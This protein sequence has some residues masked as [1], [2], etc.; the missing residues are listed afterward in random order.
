[1]C[2]QEKQASINNIAYTKRYENIVFYSN[3]MFFLIYLLT[4]HRQMF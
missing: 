4:Y 1:M 2:V 3:E